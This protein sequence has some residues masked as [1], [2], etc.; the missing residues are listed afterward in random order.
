MRGSR[1]IGLALLVVTFGLGCN[2]APTCD[3]IKVGYQVEQDT[4]PMHQCFA[5]SSLGENL[6]GQCAPT[7][8]WECAVASPAHDVYGSTCTGQYQCFVQLDA[9]GKVLCVRHFC[10]D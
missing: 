10:E 6:T 3:S 9:A 1:R 7:G 2:T 8:T 4:S 5:G